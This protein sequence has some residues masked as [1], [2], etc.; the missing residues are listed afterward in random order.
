MEFQAVLEAVRSWPVQD[1]KRLVHLIQDELET[2]GVDTLLTPEQMQELDRR[3]A[4]AEANPDEVVPWEDVLAQA[5][6]RHD[7]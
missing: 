4:D 5:R 7:R 1:Q 6:A 3:L 2:Q